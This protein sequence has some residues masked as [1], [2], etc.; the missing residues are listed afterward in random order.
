MSS[1]LSVLA[2][3]ISVVSL[4]WSVHTGR[5]RS[6]VDDLRD[7]I[8]HPDRGSTFGPI[9]LREAQRIVLPEVVKLSRT[10]NYEGTP[11]KVSSLWSLLTPH[12]E[13]LDLSSLHRIYGNCMPI[14][15]KDLSGTRL[16]SSP[17]RAMVLIAVKN[18]R[19]V[20]L[21]PMR[22]LRFESCD[23]RGIA[24]MHP[25]CPYFSFTGSTPP[26]SWQDVLTP[27]TEDQVARLRAEGIKGMDTAEAEAFYAAV[28]DART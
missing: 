15:G 21:P 3:I 26:D 14:A 12:L 1:V 5:R 20:V 17:G 27:T 22:D 25:P 10:L 9:S 24:A 11:D 4:A 13:R 19:G 28:E 18:M 23:L 2:L 8:G 16:G 7:L 6:R